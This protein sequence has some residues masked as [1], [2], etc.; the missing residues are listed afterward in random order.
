MFAT[1][2]IFFRDVR[3]HQ[4]VPFRDSKLTRLLQSFFTGRGKCSMVVNVSQS[5]Y[6]FDESLQV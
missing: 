2:Y 6:L 4:I 3:K 1:N 5:P